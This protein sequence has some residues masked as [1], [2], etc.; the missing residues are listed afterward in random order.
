MADAVVFFPVLPCGLQTFGA[1]IDVFRVFSG[2]LS[3]GWSYR[4]PQGLWCCW[5]HWK[6]PLGVAVVT[7]LLS[8]LEV[9]GS[10]GLG[11]VVS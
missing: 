11:A 8:W 5:T 2:G 4:S 6:W 10:R 9:L 7:V 1:V 3:S